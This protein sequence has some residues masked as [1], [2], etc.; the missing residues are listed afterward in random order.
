M[1]Y[2]HWAAGRWS[3]N[4]P[5]GHSGEVTVNQSDRVTGQANYYTTK[6]TIEKA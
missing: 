1:E 6:V 2:G 5:G 3:K 4:V